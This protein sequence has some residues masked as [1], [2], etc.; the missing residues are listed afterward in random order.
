MLNRTAQT[1]LYPPEKIFLGAVASDFRRSQEVTIP[2][3]VR[4]LFVATTLYFSHPENHVRLVRRYV[5]FA[6]RAPPR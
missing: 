5:L 2:T 4:Q 1:F 3:V 6:T